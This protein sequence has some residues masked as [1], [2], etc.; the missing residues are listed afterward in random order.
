MRRLQILPMSRGMSVSFT[1][2]DLSGGSNR[3]IIL[4]VFFGMMLDQQR[5]HAVLCSKPKWAPH[6][7]SC[8]DSAGVG[9]A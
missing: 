5:H 9:N 2:M 8:S 6:E 3:V 7:A 1:T 4:I